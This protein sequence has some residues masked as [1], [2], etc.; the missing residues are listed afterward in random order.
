MPTLGWTTVN[1]APT[2]EQTLLLASRFEVWHWWQVPGFMRQSMRAWRQV[3][4]APRALGA[5]LRAQPLRRVFWTLSAWESEEA[6][7]AYAHAHPHS[8]VMRRVRR[9]TKSATLVTWTIASDQLPPSW[10]EAERRIAEQ[11]ADT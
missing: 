6:L 5:T 9:H 2:H 7:H 4:T 8:E 1:P 3:T 11:Q 10:T